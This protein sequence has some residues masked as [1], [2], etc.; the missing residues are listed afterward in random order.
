[1]CRS[2]RAI[3]EPGRDEPMF[4]IPGEW[5][6]GA[7]LCLLAQAPSPCTVGGMWVGDEGAKLIYQLRGTTVTVPPLS[8]FHPASRS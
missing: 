3:S 6:S 4:E 8:T 7:R 5:N 1:M 2:C